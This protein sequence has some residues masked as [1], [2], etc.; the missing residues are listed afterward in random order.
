[1]RAALVIAILVC[2][3]TLPTFAQFQDLKSDQPIE[4]LSDKVEYLRNNDIAKF[5]GNVEATQGELKLQCRE[6]VVYFEKS[7]GENVAE[8]SQ[9]N[10]I[11]L[12]ELID[13][14]IIK[15]LDDEAQANW[16]EYKVAQDL[17]ELKGNVMLRQKEDVMYGDHLTYRRKTQEAVLHSG[18]SSNRV[19]G[20]FK[21]RGQQN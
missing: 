15:N 14:V 1:M 10:S 16:G 8:K 9:A 21:A 20:V 3:Y 6:M 5:K 7:K 2:I 17:F 18:N 19:R 13:N 4:I 12:I 11:K